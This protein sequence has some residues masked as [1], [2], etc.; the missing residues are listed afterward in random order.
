MQ[1]W[2]RHL[3]L[4][5]APGILAFLI[6]Q[7]TRKYAATQFAVLALGAA[8]GAGLPVDE[9]VLRRAWTWWRTSP[10][11]DGGF[12]YASGGSKASAKAIM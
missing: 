6:G 9:E 3:T 7:C 8:V 10:Q 1:R 12:G 11:K 2:Q 5:L 4:T